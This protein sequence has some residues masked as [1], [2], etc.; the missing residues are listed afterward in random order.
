M[1]SSAVVILTTLT[2][3]LS[4]FAYNHIN[5]F[6]VDITVT[7]TEVEGLV[8]S[9]EQLRELINAQNS[10]MTQLHNIIMN[11]LLTLDKNGKTRSDREIKNTNDRTS[12]LVL[13]TIAAAIIASIVVIV[14]LTICMVERRVE[15][16]DSMSTHT[17]ELMAE[18]KKSHAAEIKSP[19]Q[20][21]A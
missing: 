17:R 2:L 13:V 7:R 11:D 6:V 1:Q 15:T 20:F 9:V 10:T 21:T 5:Q 18:I 3:V 19:Q 8:K 4:W 14:T 12:S 16:I